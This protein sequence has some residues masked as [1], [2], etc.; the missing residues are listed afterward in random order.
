MNLIQLSE[1]HNSDL[2]PHHYSM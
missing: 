2:A 1:S